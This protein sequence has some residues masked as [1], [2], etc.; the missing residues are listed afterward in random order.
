MKCFQIDFICFNHSLTNYMHTLQSLQLHND[1]MTLFYNARKSRNA[2]IGIKFK[3][4][5]EV[6][7]RV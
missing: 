5:S 2:S 7:K 6:I 4:L 1:I 3:P